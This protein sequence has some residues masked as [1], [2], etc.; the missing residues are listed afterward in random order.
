MNGGRTKAQAKIK[1][2]SKVFS[3]AL[4]IT[5]CLLTG[6]VQQNRQAV[7]R[8]TPLTRNVFAMDTY[9][10]FTVY[11]NVPETVLQSAETRLEELEN[12]WSVTEEKSEI[13]AVNHASGQPVAV[14]ESTADLLRFA[15]KMSDE[16]DGSLDITTYPLLTAWGF[17]TD[18]YQ[19]PTDEQIAQLLPYIGYDKVT[20]SGN[21]VTLLPG[22]EI[23]LGAV[24]KGYACDLVTQDMK[25]QGVTSAIISL[26]GNIGAIGSKPDG[27]DWKISLRHPINDD[28]LGILSLSDVS[29]VTS[30]AY[31]H[32]FDGEDGKRYGHI[33][34]PSTGKPAESDLVSVTVIGKEGKICDALST[35]FYVMGRSAA[36][37]YYREH[38]DI[39]LLLFTVDGEIH[40]TSGLRDSFVPAEAY[41]NIPVHEIKR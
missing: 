9:N 12:L 23:D 15:L 21:S 35:A 22:M 19:V 8:S 34:N 24:G 14:S 33:L 39:E 26:G 37:E 20:L 11:D 13:Y 25:D 32:Y 3:A 40:L 16:T 38:G 41:Q 2:I 30:G 10:T 6:C 29:V 7:Y 28:S 17:T 1:R 4:I 36:E 31:E 27:T 5:C 18:S